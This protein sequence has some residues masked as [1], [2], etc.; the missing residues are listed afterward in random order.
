M[1]LLIVDDEPIIVRGL[2]QL[3]DYAEL[4]YDQVLTAEKSSDALHL[5]RTL[6]PEA[7]LSDIAMPGLT[8]LEL[9][10]LIRDES[11]QT[12][13]VFLSGFRSFEYAQEA[14]TLGAKDYLVKPVDAEKLSAD[15]REIAETHQQLQ[16]RNRLQRRLETIG[17]EE[18][19]AFADV[20]VDERP[21]CLG[22][23]RLSVD[24]QQSSLSVGLMHFSA[25]SKGEAFCGER[26]CPTFLQEDC[27]CVIFHGE[28]ETECFD[29]A[30]SLCEECSRAVEKAMVRPFNHVIYPRLLRSAR[31]IPEAWKY[32]VQQLS[33]AHRD[34][35][36]DDSLIEKIRDYI[37]GHYG[38]DLTLEAMSDIFAMNPSYFSHYFHQKTGIRY[39]DYLTRIRITEAKRL[40][41]KGDLKIYEISQQVGFSDVRWFSQIFMKFTGVLPKDYKGR[42][43]KS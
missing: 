14:L 17:Q 38:E 20:Q 16:V 25:L 6:Q 33:I 24:E 9:L 42:Q 5:L 2:V 7:M 4:G 40:L 39:K 28:N 26:G 13:V 3:I 22:C 31:E 11:M 30:R 37:A 29:L 35:P 1:K 15:L 8:G 10:R 43:N 21:F 23:F 18:R 36:V 19:P 27:L 41:L 34:Q 12:Q 32:C